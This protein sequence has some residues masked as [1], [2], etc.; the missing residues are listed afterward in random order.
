MLRFSDLRAV[1]NYIVDTEY[2][3]TVERHLAELEARHE[4]G[5]LAPLPDD[6]LPF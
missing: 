3:A 4:R 5:E 2:V 1:V 6:D